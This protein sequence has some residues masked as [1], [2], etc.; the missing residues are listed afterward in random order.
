MR[1]SA[2]HP[3]SRRLG[4]LR[5]RAFASVGAT[6]LIILAGALFVAAFTSSGTKAIDSTNSPTA[7]DAPTDFTF[8]TPLQLPKPAPNPTVF[9]IQDAEPEIKGDLFGN[10]Y[11]TAI[12]G[13]PGGTD[14]WKSINGGGSFAYLGQPDGLQD[15]CATPTPQCLG[16]G[17]ADDSIDVSTGGYL[18]VSSLY[19]GSVTH[20]TSMD[21]GTGGVEPGQAWVT[22]PVSTGAP[23]EDRQWI[24]AYGPQTVNM[25]VRQAPGTGRLL[26]TKSTDAGKTFSA[27]IL[28]T[29][30]NSTEG[31]LVADPYTGYLYTS[32][33]PSAALNRIDLL[34]STDGGATWS[35]ITGIYTGPASA[36]P[37]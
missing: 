26:Y 20:S 36:D 24:A 6:L 9:F 19:I 27:P 21:G 23:V 16:A 13:V 5:Q 17:G 10:I 8:S 34:K 15:K 31:N 25:T 28:L 29:S 1:T 14:L 35:T 2:E 11:I 32:F 3:A 33:I 22:N 7:T 18:Y 37:G 12:N 30:A 4:L